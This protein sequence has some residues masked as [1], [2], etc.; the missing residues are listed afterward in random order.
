MKRKYKSEDLDINEWVL[1]N[2]KTGETRELKEGK[3]SIL[4]PTKLVKLHS[5][6]YFIFDTDRLN[7]LLEKGLTDIHIGLLALMSSNLEFK[8]NICL[9]QDGKPHTSSNIAE[10]LGQTQQAVI[11]KLKKLQELG[12]IKKTTIPENKHLGKVYMVNPYLL[13]KGKDFSVFLSQ[14]F[15]DIVPE[16]KDSGEPLLLQK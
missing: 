1:V 13:R 4:S 14:I 10:L 2:N 5:A 3:I 9:T 8:F 6:N 15:Y 16:V 11:R 7:L 12:I